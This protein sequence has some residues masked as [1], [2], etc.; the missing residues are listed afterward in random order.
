MPQQNM[1]LHRVER[2][3]KYAVV[4]LTAIEDPRLTG[5]AKALHTYAMTRPDA[6]ELKTDDIYRRFREGKDAIGAAF[7]CLEAHGYLKRER[8]RQDGGRW[9]WIYTWYERPVS[10]TPDFPE[11]TDRSGSAAPENPEWPPISNNHGRNDH[12]T[13]HQ[14]QE[15]AALSKSVQVPDVG[16]L[17]PADAA[18]V[19]ECCSIVWAVDGYTPRT[20]DDPRLFLALRREFRRVN[21]LEELRG[22]A[23]YQET[24]PIRNG[25]GPNRIRNW[26]RIA[27]ERRG[28]HRGREPSNEREFDAFR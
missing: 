26:I 15:P 14:E 9:L 10:S 21:I 20:K 8:S 23:L 6:W 7:K 22:W 25:N 24:H 5:T 12:G 4:H 17:E 19:G 11:R 3:R 27:S 28:R 2:D 16:D 18:F 1:V 13:I